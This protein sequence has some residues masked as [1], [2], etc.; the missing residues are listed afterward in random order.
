MSNRA[1]GVTLV[2]THQVILLPIESSR[3]EDWFLYEGEKFVS[4]RPTESWEGKPLRKAGR[5][6]G[7]RR[8]D[9]VRG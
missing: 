1:R 2:T 3:P 6:R 7:L 8:G 4:I 9:L 5:A